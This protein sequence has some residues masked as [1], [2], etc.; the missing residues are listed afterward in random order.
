[1]GEDQSGKRHTLDV[2]AVTGRL[3]PKLLCTFGEE[4]RRAL[5]VRGSR[6]ASSE[7]IGGKDEQI[8]P[9]IRGADGISRI[10]RH[11]LLD[12]ARGLRRCMRAAH[13]RDREDYQ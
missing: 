2:E 9:Q 10:E 13:D 7:R 12:D 11:R 4:G 3:E 1:M 8:T 6:L 5:R